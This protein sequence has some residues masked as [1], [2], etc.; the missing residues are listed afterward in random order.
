MKGKLQRIV[1]TIMR[2]PAVDT[3]TAF[4]GGGGS[5]RNTGRM[6]IAL[7]PIEQRKLTADQVIGRLR[8]GLSEVA[9]APTFLQGVQDVRVGGRLSGAQYQYTLRGDSLDELM[10]WAPRVEAQLRS[11]SRGGRREQRPAG[12]GAAVYDS[13]GPP[14]GVAI[15]HYPATN[16]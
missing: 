1:D 6:F 9:G 2:D 3:V 13:S 4:T 14:Y 8:K 11:A 16:R 12:Q 10:M 5:T 15:R 7:K